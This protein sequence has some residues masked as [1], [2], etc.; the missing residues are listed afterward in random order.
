MVQNQVYHIFDI[1]DSPFETNPALLYYRALSF[2]LFFNPFFK[3]NQISL[4]LVNVKA[5]L[6]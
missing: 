5:G 1:S 2:F 4:M 6:E 3:Y